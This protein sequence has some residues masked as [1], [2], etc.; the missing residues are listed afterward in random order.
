MLEQGSNGSSGGF[1]RLVHSTQGYVLPVQKCR[2][3][4]GV[5]CTETSDRLHRK[6]T[7]SDTLRF[8]VCGSRRRGRSRAINAILAHGEACAREYLRLQT[9]QFVGEGT[10]VDFGQHA[11]QFA[12]SFRAIKEK[13]NKPHLPFS[14]DYCQCGD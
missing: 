5:G 3:S 14:A 9:P 1:G 13:A 8:C 11:T 4:C 6:V 2:A 12:E 7:N 10:A